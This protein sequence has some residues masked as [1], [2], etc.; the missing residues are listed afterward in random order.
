MKTQIRIGSVYEYCNELVLII[1]EPEFVDGVGAYVK[2]ALIDNR[3][4]LAYDFDLIQGSF[5]AKGELYFYAWL[6][7]LH[8]VTHWGDEKAMAV[9]GAVWTD[10]KSL[11]GF[12]TGAPLVKPTSDKES[13]DKVAHVDRLLD[14][15]MQIR[16]PIN[17][18]LGEK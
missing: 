10:C 17:I 3:V 5:V 2:C 1:G 6:D 11:E 8:Y 7:G 15:V 12:E 14:R 13:S 16:V 4:D 18:L 9:S